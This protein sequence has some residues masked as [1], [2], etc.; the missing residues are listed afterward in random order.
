MVFEHI[1]KLKKEYTD[2]YVKVDDSQPELRR[3][4][5]DVGVVKTV[6][7]SGRA[8][9]E[10]TAANNIGWYDIDVDYLSIVDKPTEKKPAAKEKPAAKAK[11]AAKSAAAAGKK[12][13]PLEMA[14]AQGAGGGAAKP[15]ATKAPAAA[16]QTTAEIM[17]SARKPKG[18][19]SAAAETMAAQRTPKSDGAA[20]P[21]APA[22]AAGQDL[23]KL[24]MADKLA[25]MRG[26]SAPAAPAAE[27][28]PAAEE[29]PAAEAAPVAEEAVAVA[30]APAEAV[31][32]AAGGDKP[33]AG[34]LS[35]ADAIAW[36]RTNDAE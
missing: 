30:E 25:M 22:P 3:F 27:K 16:A 23:T 19:S 15:A 2:K 13:S 4:K 7:M 32:P 29:T 14:R 12:M 11:P 21:V 9:V 26:G 1:E 28:A 10:F 24:S 8:L 36:C 18:G 5:D 20:A 35:T 33:K 31:A 17:A 34:E 6:N